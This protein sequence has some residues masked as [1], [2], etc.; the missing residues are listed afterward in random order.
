MRGVPRWVAVL[1]VVA[2]GAVVCAFTVRHAMAPATLMLQLSPTTLPADGFTSTELKI[3]PSNGR[4]LRDLQVTVEDPHRAAVESV[5]IDGEG[6]MATA[7]LRA[8]VL[9]GETKVRVTGRGFAAQEIA[10]AQRSTAVT[11]S[12]TALRTSC[13][14]TIL[15]TAWLSAGGLPCWL[16]R[17]I[18]ADERCPPKLTIAPRSCASPTV[19]PC[20]R[21]TPLGRARWRCRRRLRQ[22]TSSNI[23]TPTLRWRRHCF[24]CVVE[25]FRPAISATAPSRNSRMW[26][27][28]G[29]TTPI[30]SAATYRAL[31]PATCCSSAR[32]ARGCHSTR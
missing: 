24:G 7:S 11:R 28:F 21:T 31:G 22:A 13:A 26:K 4:P 10:L 18:S 12:A 14:C 27:R 17:S 2:T 23:N 15:P 6:D 32:M 19:K 29:G 8:G 25:A 16:R 9:P 5:T 3:T 20:A 30:S 1:A